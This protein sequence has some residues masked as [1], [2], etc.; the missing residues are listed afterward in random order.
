MKIGNAYEKVGVLN[1]RRCKVKKYESTFT[2][3]NS[4]LGCGQRRMWI[5]R[6]KEDLLRRVVDGD[7]GS[8]IR[9]FFREWE[10]VWKNCKK[11]GVGDP[12]IPKSRNLLH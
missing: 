7:L 10:E 12:C 6:E 8:S 5:E 11:S 3:M 9:G 4:V 2:V 1:V